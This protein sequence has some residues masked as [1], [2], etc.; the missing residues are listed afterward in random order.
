MLYEPLE[1]RC[2]LNAADALFRKD[3]VRLKAGQEYQLTQ[4]VHLRSN[5][6]VIGNS[7]NQSAHGQAV[8]EGQ[9]H[10][11]STPACTM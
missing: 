5:Q 8:K 11:S 9:K 1:S 4:P 10:L 6:R 2:L 3:V 7:T